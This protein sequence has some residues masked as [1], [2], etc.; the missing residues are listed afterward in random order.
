[1]SDEL[2]RKRQERIA[3]FK[4]DLDLDDN[5]P[6]ASEQA[7]SASAANSPSQPAPVSA[8][9]GDM[10]DDH[11]EGELKS[12]SVSP[13]ANAAVDK[14]SLKKAKKADRKRRR[15]K[16]KKNRVVFRVVW[17]AMVLFISV[18]VGEF[19][20][21]GVN[22]M[23][24]VGREQ[25]G[26]VTI[27]IPKDADI[28]T[29]TDILYE[30]NVI[31]VKWFFKLYATM[32]KAT[33]G[34]TQGTFEIEKNKDY[35]ALINYMQSDM[36]RTDVVTIRFTEGMSLNQYAKLLSDARVCNTNEFL[37]AC[38]SD[39]YDEYE[40]LKNIP[41]DPKREIKLEGYLF[42]DTYDF[43]V[44]EKVDSVIE[45]FLA[46][47]RRKVYGTKSR[48]AG[49]DKKMTVAERAEAIGMSMED[50]LTLASLIQAEAANKD[51]MYM[52]SAILHNRLATI[53]NEG[54]NDNGEFGLNYLQLDSTK[55]YPYASYRDIPKDIRSTFKSRYNTYDHDGL[56]PGPINNPG[57]EAIEAALTV[58]KTDYYYFCHKS[59][60][61]NSPAV[62]Y[63][64]ATL[65]EHEKNK[66]EAGLVR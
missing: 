7:A 42:P 34:F 51:D 20:M 9:A 37:A 36:N 6:E 15:K 23:L 13:E 43:Y 56:P 53:P 26:K 19:I 33:T 49:Y 28:D 64:A 63:Y 55:Y 46:N 27:T 65:E 35:Q 12:Y 45:K 1:M 17:I 29:I 3:N 58:G 32:T 59:V 66:K 22:D 62:A 18:M 21:V 10:H 4:L 30:K 14:K 48:V 8:D 54:V 16:A 39:R 61:G 5:P 47:Y 50:V 11:D 2:E 44:G 25:E 52:I 57:L 24:G 40:F 41:A 31:N 38:N 60:S